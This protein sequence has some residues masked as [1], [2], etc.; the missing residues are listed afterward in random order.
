MSNQPVC[1]LKVI[2]NAKADELSFKQQLIDAKK[3]IA[4][5]KLQIKWLERLYE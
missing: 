2:K 5:L 3:E 4:D 1:L